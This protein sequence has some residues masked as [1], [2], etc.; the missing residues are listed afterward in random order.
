VTVDYFSLGHPLARLRSHYAWRARERMLQRFL[1]VFRPGPQTR[2]LDLGV[3][4]DL[5]LPESNHFEQRY[6]FPGSLTAASIED[7]APLRGHFPEVALVRIGL[8]DL[9]FA[10][11]TFDLVFCS[12]VLEHVGDQDRQRH[13]I[14]ELMRVGKGF[15]LTT[16]NRWFPLEFHTLLPVLH[17]LPQR[18]H[19]QA[20]R[21]LGKPFWASTDNLNLLS[22]GRL[23]RL[24][25][26][27]QQPIVESVRLW[28][29]PSNLIA[30]GHIQRG[31]DSDRLAVGEGGPIHART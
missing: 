13:F 9:P 26:A 6:P 19:Q 22:A 28:G 8:E 10:D 31:C 4:P 17:W 29:W 30:H 11:G 21:R 15:F 23:R 3:T 1:T 14:S 2:V 16:P 20:L 12:A 18:R 7:I 27:S 5:T 24:F 25:P